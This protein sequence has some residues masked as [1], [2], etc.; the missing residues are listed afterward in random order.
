MCYFQPLKL[1]VYVLGK[2]LI[3]CPAVSCFLMILLFSPV[4]LESVL[5]KRNVVKTHP[6]F[7]KEIYI[8]GSINKTVESHHISNVKNIEED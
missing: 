7:R 6:Q 4:K 1:Y 2:P 5:P 8:Q 3:Y